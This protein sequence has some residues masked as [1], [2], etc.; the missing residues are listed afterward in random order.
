MNTKSISKLQPWIVCLTA[1]LFF[2]FEFFQINMFNVL[3]T[4][5]I[6]EFAINASGLGMI[7]SVY[8]Y[9]TVFLLLPAGIVL[10]FLSVRKLILLSMCVS[11]IGTLMFASAQSTWQLMAARLIVGIGAGP[12][13]LLSAIKLASRWFDAKQIGLAIG[14]IISLGMVAGII[15]QTPFAY[16][17]SLVGWRNAVLVDAMVG[18]LI[19]ITIWFIV[20]DF[21]IEY[22]PHEDESNNKLSIK[23]FIYNAKEAAK[24]WPNWGAGIFAG[25]LN[26]PIFLLGSLIGSLY[27]SQIYNY[28]SITSSFI[29][30][31]LYWG[32][33]VG[34]TS[35]G[36]ISD[37]IRSRKKPMLFGGTLTVI[38]LCYLIQNNSCS[39]IELITLFFIIG[40]GAS[41]HI[42]AYPMIAEEN[43]KSQMASGEGIAATLIMSGGAIFQP[44]L[45]WL[46]D[47]NWNGFMLN[48][49]PIYSIADYNRGFWLMPITIIIAICILLTLKEART[50]I[51]KPI[52]EPI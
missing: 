35:F 21:P 38:A 5:L 12:F 17:V 46:I 45:G 33:L 22:V 16:T 13:C 4:H 48:G 47:L 18:V 44:I 39:F 52:T 8:F 20:K 26:L 42:L 31:M 29:N 37:Q 40:F 23:S 10:D 14:T 41:S 15:S 7:S 36:F 34:C 2:C 3:D 24:R 11:V 28:S 1:G 50:V 27:L 9:G 6:Q 19:T 51:I 43:P 32:M 30:S 49:S 25:L